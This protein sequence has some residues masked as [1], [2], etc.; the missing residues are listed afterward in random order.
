MFLKQGNN[1]RRFIEYNYVNNEE[2]DINKFNIVH[3]VSD[4]IYNTTKSFFKKNILLLDN[5][6]FS[7]KFKLAFK[8]QL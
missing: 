2:I 6:A 8:S 4:D 5:G 1:S 3:N 7:N